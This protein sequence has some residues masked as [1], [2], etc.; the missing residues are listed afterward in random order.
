MACSSRTAVQRGEGVRVRAYVV[1]GLIRPNQNRSRNGSP[2]PRA[3]HPRL[4]DG[5]SAMDYDAATAAGVHM[6][7]GARA[8]PAAPMT[9]AASSP[10]LRPTIDG[11]QG[12]L[13]L[14]FA[15][16][17]SASPLF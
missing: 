10:S 4:I 8:G 12:G 3:P 9:D 17:L 11:G 1:V 7:G 6:R 5:L 16:P 13:G 14:G 2:V 15:G